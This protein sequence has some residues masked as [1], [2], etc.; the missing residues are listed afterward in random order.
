MEI[1]QATQADLPAVM[2]VIADAQAYMRACGVDQWQ[3]GYPPVSVFTADIEKGACFM[4]CDGE[5]VTGT[6]ALLFGDDPNYAIL[7]SGAWQTRGAYATVH[8]IAVSADARG[9]GAAD[10]LFRHCEQ[11]A[12]GAGVK[13]LRVDTHKDNRAM[14][15]ALK[16]HGY[17]YVG[18]L[19]LYRGTGNELPRIAFEKTL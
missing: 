8:R 15:G 4:L 14:Q 9:T 6:C 17:S 11:L 5:R 10:L 1:R 18:E 7:D 13:N 19:M 16:R 3:D 2:A 12:R